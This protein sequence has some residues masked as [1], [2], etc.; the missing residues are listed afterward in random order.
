M[1][2][3]LVE[4][5]S[6]SNIAKETKEEIEKDVDQEDDDEGLATNSYS[7]TFSRRSPGWFLTMI[8]LLRYDLLC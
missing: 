7:L 5:F 8:T 1:I 4:N 2:E 3:D 6:K